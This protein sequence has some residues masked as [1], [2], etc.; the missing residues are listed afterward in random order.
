MTNQRWTRRSVLRAG[1][2]AGTAGL[3]GCV[4]LLGSSTP[5]GPPDEFASASFRG[6][7]R[8]HGYRPDVTVPDAVTPAWTVDNVNVG[9]HTAAKAGAVRDPDGNYLISGDSGEVRSVTLDGEQRWVSK[10]G[11]STRGIHGTPAIANGLLYIGAYDG[12]MYAFDLDSGDQVWR[13]DLGGSI[14][15]SPKYH[16]GVVYIAVEYPT[17]SGSVCGVDALTGERVFYDGTPTDHP[18]STIAIDR[19]AGRLV[20]GS[21]DGNLYG[22]SYPELDQLWTFQTARAIKGPIATYDGSAFFGSWD[23]GVYRVAL[24][25][26]TEEWAIQTADM[27]M[28]GSSIDTDAD[29][30]YIGG[31]DTKLHALDVA[32]GDEHWAYETD[33]WIIGSPT[34]THDRILVGSYDGNLHAVE[35]ASGERVWT[36]DV[37]GGR[38]SAEPLVDDDGIVVAARATDERSGAAVRLVED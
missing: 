25:D 30:L 32:T 27:V 1:A 28:G 7:L 18:H 16:D 17:P 2:L 38:V 3:A 22:W 33:D 11:N 35:A 29:V 13:N 24:D 23:G 26:G 14:G 6:G 9:D 4:D 31:H 37:P 21:N 15:S 8:N 5:A 34:V 10:A 19:E 12:A 36:Y 20:V